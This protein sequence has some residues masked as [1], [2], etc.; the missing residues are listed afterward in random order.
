MLS[1][2]LARNFSSLKT[3]TMMLRLG[4]MKTTFLHVA[5]RNELDR[6]NYILLILKS[7]GKIL[8]F[9]EEVKENFQ[10]RIQ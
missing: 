5:L 2:H 6:N 8:L 3:G 7:A 1:M 4:F 10:Q 9:S